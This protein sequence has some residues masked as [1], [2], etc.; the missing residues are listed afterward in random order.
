MPSAGSVNGVPP[1]PP[2]GG[3]SAGPA[4]VQ[5]VPVQQHQS[6]VI[7]HPVI[8]QQ[9]P[10][11]SEGWLGQRSANGLPPG[12]VSIGSFRVPARWGGHAV[13]VYLHV[14]LLVMPLVAG[15]AI[16]AQ[17][18]GGMAFLLVLVVTGPL[19]VLMVFVHEVGHV[20]EAARHGC[21]P[22]LILLWPLGGLAVIA[23][24]A[25]D[26]KHRALIAAAGPATHV[27]MVLFWLVL[28]SCTGHFTLSTRQLLLNTPDGW[29][30]ALFVFEVVYNLATLAFNLLVPCYPLDCSQIIIS[31][32]CVHGWPKL[33]IAEA[34]LAS[35]CVVLFLLAGYAIWGMGSG[36]PSAALGLF[37]VIWLALQSVTLYQAYQ[38]GEPGLSVHPLFRDNTAVAA[39][40]GQ[41]R[42]HPTEREAPGNGRVCAGAVLV[43]ALTLA[44]VPLH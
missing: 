40:V 4:V 18:G 21:T 9:R 28:L 36:E 29:L 8:V 34:I 43:V 31:L 32:L 27:P 41:P 1:P 16:L 14:M 30:A 12:T 26:P 7:V 22:R 3:G 6:A 15:L 37:T 5:G 11:T 17:G 35:S 25:V 33:K 39:S 10:L 44:W 20:A 42:G 2:H 24:T 23:T 19:L 38:L 13:P